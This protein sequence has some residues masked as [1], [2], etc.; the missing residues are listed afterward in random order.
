M[1][2]QSFIADIRERLKSE[3]K[4]FPIRGTFLVHD[5]Q[6]PRN[7]NGTVYMALVLRDRDGLINAKMWDNVEESERRVPFQIGDFIQLQG[8]ALLY[9]G[10]PQLRVHKL[11]RV[12]APAP[13]ELS[14]FLGRPS[15][16]PLEMLTRCRELA[17]T[18]ADPPL[19]EMLQKR[20][21]DPDFRDQ[22]A[23]A[24][25]AKS[26]HHAHPG[27]LLEHTLAVMELADKIAG[28]YAALDRDLLLAGAFLHD[29]GKLRE[30]RIDAGIS[31][32]DEGNLIGHLVLGVEMLSEWAADLPE[33]TFLKLRHMI[34]S[35]HGRK[36]FGSPVVPKFPE[37]FLLHIL[38]NLDSKLKTMF[39][40]AAREAGQ[41]WSSFQEQFDGNLFLEGEPTAPLQ[42][43]SKPAI[44]KPAFGE[45]AF[46]GE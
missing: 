42:S 12:E 29:M 37:A 6:L 16:E 20:L 1:A 36:E 21:D 41:R 10:A 39:E 5:K 8:E 7:K 14:D 3:A 40:V 11:L 27:G 31:Y 30:L 46:G 24:P 35:H 34:L 13:A 45:P 4:G 44:A 38:D 43:E 9:R 28:Q 18:I 15:R 22:L 17:L 23:A 19:R 2:G 33:R 26:H 32:T 25:A